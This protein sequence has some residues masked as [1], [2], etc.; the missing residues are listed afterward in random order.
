MILSGGGGG[1]AVTWAIS[2][3]SASQITASQILSAI[4]LV[5][6]TASG[7]GEAGPG[8]AGAGEAWGEAVLLGTHLTH[9]VRVRVRG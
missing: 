8:E 5:R 6:S 4:V 9:L 1:D 2:A 3:S 7:P